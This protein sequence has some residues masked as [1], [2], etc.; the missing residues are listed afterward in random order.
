MQKQFWIWIFVL[1]FAS[2]AQADGAGSMFKKL[3]VAGR[4]TLEVPAKWQT[5]D[6]EL[7]D[8]VATTVEAMM[9]NQKIEGVQ[10][11]QI[12]FTMYPSK[13]L[14]Q[15]AKLNLTRTRG[16]AATQAQM[17]AWSAAEVENIN[18]PMRQSVLGNMPPEARLVRWEP[19]V[20]L[21]QN[22]TA[23][24]VTRFQVANPDGKTHVI[25]MRAASITG[26]VWSALCGYDQKA[27]YIYKPVCEK[28]LGS[29][30]LLPGV[31]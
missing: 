10:G 31:K 19:L 20:R 29:L 15:A 16:V 4:V 2:H 6:G 27:E 21:E 8:Q 17:R 23:V 24:L 22:G 11:T 1:L 28:V 18:Q 5:L 25:Q 7:A 9:D 3:T 14:V 12:M 26:E 30:T 13:N